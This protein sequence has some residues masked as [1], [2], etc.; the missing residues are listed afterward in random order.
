MR[1]DDH[2]V[3][4]YRTARDACGAA[5]LALDAARD[6]A[7]DPL[8]AQLLADMATLVR[9]YGMR[10]DAAVQALEQRGG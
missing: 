9:Q 1:T 3:A 10:L 5:A 6:V 7:A 4:A 8:A 2:R